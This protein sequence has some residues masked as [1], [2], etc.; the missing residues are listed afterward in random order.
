VQFFTAASRGLRCCC[1]PL[2]NCGCQ[3][4]LNC[5]V[6]H[7]H[8][9]TPARTVTGRRY[10]SVGIVVKLHVFQVIVMLAG[11]SRHK[12]TDAL[13]FVKK[14]ADYSLTLSD[15]GRRRQL[16]I[17]GVFFSQTFA[18]TVEKELNLRS[19]CRC[20]R[21]H[22]IKSVI[23]CVPWRTELFESAGPAGEART[24][25]EDTNSLMFRTTA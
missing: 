1:T 2:V 7:T 9:I 10:C 17:T 11:F 25:C 20:I 22:Y 19:H 24:F 8:S 16:Q 18:S 5:L 13:E 3:G 12:L 14:N 15:D 23:C 6:A 4:R 21:L